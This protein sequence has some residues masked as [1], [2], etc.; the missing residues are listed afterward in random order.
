MW[1]RV[2]GLGEGV[3]RRGGRKGEEECPH[4]TQLPQLAPVQL[5]PKERHQAR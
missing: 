5:R 2:A 3:G 4:F 1:L